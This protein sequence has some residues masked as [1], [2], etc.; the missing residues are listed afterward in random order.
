MMTKDRVTHYYP[1]MPDEIDFDNLSDPFA[2]SFRAYF[3]GR[4][5]MI[6]QGTH[7]P[8]F[9][10][11][12][13]SSAYPHILRQLPN[14]RNGD[15]RDYHCDQLLTPGDEDQPISKF[16]RSDE[17]LR[18]MVGHLNKFS[19]LSMVQVQFYFPAC[20]RSVI[21]AGQ[22][23]IIRAD[24]PWFPLPIRADDGTI[25]F[26]RQGQGLYMVE[27]VRAM[28]R[29]A[30][31]V[32]ANAKDDERPMVALWHAMEFCPINNA[33][34]F[35]ARIERD[36]EERAAIIDKTEADKLNWKNNGKVGPE[37]YDVREKVLK[38]G[39]NSIYGKTAQSKGARIAHDA[40]GVMRSKPPKFSNIYYA[41]AVTA[42]TRAMLLDAAN[43]D[44]DAIILFATDGICSVREL[45]GL[46]ISP[47][48]TLGAWEK[49][50]RKNGVFVKAGI[51]SHEPYDDP[52]S[53]GSSAGG[54]PAKRITKM[55]GIRP[56]SLSR[57]KTAEQWLIEEV[58]Q[59]WKRDDPSLK[60]SYR[61]YKT[62]GAALAS[63]KSWELAG[64]W[65][66]GMREADIQHVSA[67]RDSRGVAR[68]IMKDGSERGGDRRRAIA[69]FDTAPAENP[70]GWELSHP[71]SPDW[72]DKELSTRVQAEEEQKT[73]EC[74]SGFA[75]HRE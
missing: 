33:R 43:G 47:T 54:R 58:P 37:P 38:L 6:K 1:E 32:Y 26:P 75:G 72:I 74:K 34:P 67:K 11:Y 31:S 46:E 39:L 53:T 45:P 60:F 73:L 19:L 20:H 15:W 69:L 50:V 3:G 7:R 71:Y 56:A 36:F 14:M 61:A 17:D 55:R 52:V 35:K 23:M 59:A 30:K 18:L 8:Q 68:S 12:D 51:Y 13:I 27:E 40:E 49:T 16:K 44:V 42:G 70:I 24:L 63:R 62:F 41:A 2:S 28:L 5:E 4:V 66:E 29:W 25:Y 10:N 22:Q 64:H 21:R 65:I 9:W 48:K 57:G